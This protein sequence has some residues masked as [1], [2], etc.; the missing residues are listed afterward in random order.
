MAEWSV[1]NIS[2]HTLSTVQEESE[3]VKKLRFPFPLKVL[4]LSPR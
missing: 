4:K 3:Q 2:A 1:A